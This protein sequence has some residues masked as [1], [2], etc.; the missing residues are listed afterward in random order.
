VHDTPLSSLEDAPAGAGTDSAVQLDP[1]HFWLTSELELP[2]VFAPTAI[3]QLEVHD[4]PLSVLLVAP[5]GLAGLASVQ[6]E[7]FDVSASWN[8]PLLLV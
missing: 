6:A 8:V 5:G 4:T 1:V 2:V 3:H 7:P